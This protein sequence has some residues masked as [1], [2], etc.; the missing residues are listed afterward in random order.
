[1][2]AYP[3]QPTEQSQY[4][5]AHGDA[6]DAIMLAAMYMKK[7][8][9]RKHRPIFFKVGDYVALRL[10][11]GYNVPGLK[12]CNVK[13]EQQFAGPFKILECIGQLVY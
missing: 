2:P 3:V 5:A 12:N 8:F 11:R 4:R 10:H 7:N 9:D 1:M 13:I 6:Q